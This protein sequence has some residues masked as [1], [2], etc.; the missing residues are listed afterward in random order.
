MKSTF[1]DAFPKLRA[2]RA[3]VHLGDEFSWA[4]RFSWDDEAA[5]M[6]FGRI[7]VEQFV[8]FPR[9]VFTGGWARNLAGQHTDQH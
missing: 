8:T 4:T 5:I 7:V 6:S 3:M 9:F 2:V 1:E